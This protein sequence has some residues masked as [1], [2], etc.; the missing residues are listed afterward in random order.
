MTTRRGTGCRLGLP[1]YASILRALQLQPMTAEA[2]SKHI[3]LAHG[4]AHYVLRTLR[5]VKL[6]RIAA[7]ERREAPATG[8]RAVYGFGGKPDEP[9]PSPA[10]KRTGAPSNNLNSTAIALAHMLRALVRPVSVT[11]LQEVAGTD[12]GA[13][14]K[15]LA[16]CR[17]IGLARVASWQ[18]TGRGGQPLPLWQL[19]SAP[20][21]ARPPYKSRAE[22]NRQCKER[23]KARLKQLAVQQAA[24]SMVSQQVAT[25]F[26]GLLP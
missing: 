20:D 6:A 7:W 8:Y 14:S 3:G 5:T 9:H 23:R 2:V 15:F 11:G 22:I 13:T 24:F 19:G 16:H 21:A 10:F 18:T 1:G 25:P 12:R 26:G 17:D 4:R